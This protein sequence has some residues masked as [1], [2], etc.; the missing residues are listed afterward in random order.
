MADEIR[1]S[2]SQEAIAS[3]SFEPPPSP[4]NAFSQ[5]QKTLVL[6]VA[7]C[8]AVSTFFSANIYLP[9]LPTLSRELG[10][11]ISMINLTVTFFMLLFAI[12]VSRNPSQQ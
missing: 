9:L 1:I 7:T 2:S 4:Y 3:S 12:G 11:S 10:V 8:A 6:A 5:G